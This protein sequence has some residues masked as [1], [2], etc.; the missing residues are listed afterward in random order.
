MKI[1]KAA[2]FGVLFRLIACAIYGL[3]VGYL[4]SL[5]ADA[6]A[7]ILQDTRQYQDFGLLF[8]AGSGLV[9]CVIAHVVYFLRKRFS[10]N[11]HSNPV[12]VI[13]IVTG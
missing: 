11:R 9:V 4:A 2:S 12:N 7:G 3:M 1:V 5:S 13:A 10:K 6:P 8:G